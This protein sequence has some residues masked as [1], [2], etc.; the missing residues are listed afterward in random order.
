MRGT[1]I[2]PHGSVNWGRVMQYQIPDDNAAAIR[3]IIENAQDIR[4]STRFE[5]ARPGSARTDGGM[6]ILPAIAVPVESKSQFECPDDHLVRLDGLAPDVESALLIGWRGTEL[7]F[8]ERYAPSLT[9]LRRVYVIAGSK[10]NADHVANGL[11]SHGFAA[12]GQLT[13]TTTG[14]TFDS[15]IGPPCDAFLREAEN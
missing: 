10:Q 15:F 14:D 2:K 4:P 6:P 11:R 3:W 5:I 8:I 13:W 12:S 9:S 7:H 1:I